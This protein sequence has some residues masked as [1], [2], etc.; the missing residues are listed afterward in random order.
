MSYSPLAAVRHR[1]KLG[2]PVAFNIRGPDH[3]LL[4]ARGQV[5]RDDAQLNALFD[6]HAV[7]DADELK[8]PRSEVQEAPLE[9]LPALWSGSIHRVGRALLA[10]A[11]PE[12]ARLLQEAAEPVLALVERDP[13]LA[14]FQVVRQEAVGRGAYGVSHA[15]HTSIASYLVAQRLGWDI[16]SIERV[17]KAALTMN[18]AVLDLQ[19]RLATQ[20]TPLTAVQ[21]EAIHDHP[22]HS[23]EVL[24]ASGITDADWL[25]AIGSH[26]EIAG[27]LGY[28][29][30]CQDVSEMAS[31]L[32]RVDIYTAKLSPRNSRQALPA[33]QAGRD[34]FVQDGHHPMAAAIVKEFGVYPPGCFVQ[35]QCGEVGI[36]IKRGPNANTPVVAALTSRTGDALMEPVRRNTDQRGFGIVGVVPESALRVR[37]SP[38]KLVVLGAR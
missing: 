5:I 12:F 25:D 1:V 16:N 29:S 8:T 22:L 4:L 23:V 6:R 3:T 21:R 9:H 18:I 11:L 38:E 14:I 15:V 10:P 2:A 36:V 13:D 27:G 20:V 7:V 24:Q 30:R 35:L 32:R 33:N 34:L 19:S 26:H 28:P 37:V 17:F 31:L